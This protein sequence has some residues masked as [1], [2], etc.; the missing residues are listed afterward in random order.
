MKGADNI[1]WIVV[2]GAILLF[3]GLVSVN[4][5]KFSGVPSISTGEGAVSQPAALCQLKNT[6]SVTL[7]ARTTNPLNTS[8]TN[9]GATL[10]YVV[11]ADTGKY[12]GSGTTAVSGAYTTVSTTAACGGNYRL[13]AIGNTSSQGTST[14]KSVYVVG[15]LIGADETG[16]KA[17][18]LKD[19]S[20]PLASALYFK[21][22]DNNYVNLYGN[23]NWQI[24][25]ATANKTGAALGNDWTFYVTANIANSSAQYGSTSDGAVICADFDTTKYSKDV[26]SVS[27]GGATVISV[28]SY[29]ASQG[30][31]KAWKVSAITGQVVYSVYFKADKGAPTGGVATESP[32]LY[33]FDT[34]GF[35]KT[36]STIG[37]GIADEGDVLV[38]QTDNY[39][40]L[41]IS[42][43]SA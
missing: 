28:P 42:P 27:G 21:A 11:D 22:T 32:Y 4:T 8:G 17:T 36:D 31:D 26:F 43:A 1:L 15:N 30:Y 14:S 16:T 7:Q 23:T 18:V 29:C 9:Y 2:I 33:F 41:G 19:L 6:D 10:L 25:N 13:V 20:V 5:G 38:G 34:N 37:V 40:R 24:N 35:V 3:S 12:I 39:V